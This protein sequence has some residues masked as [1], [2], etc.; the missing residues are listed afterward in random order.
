MSE[1]SKQNYYIIK[2][3]FKLMSLS[4]FFLTLYRASKA[5][6]APALP[7]IISNTESSLMAFEEI[8]VVA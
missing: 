4:K 3:N 6:I 2:E 5:D 1:F 8:K 7:P